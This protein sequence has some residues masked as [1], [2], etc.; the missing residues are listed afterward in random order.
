MSVRNLDSLFNPSS[1]ALVGSSATPQTVGAVATRN[2]FAAGFHG[3]VYLVNPAGIVFGENASIDVN[4]S[5]H[6]S[7]ADYLKLGINGRFDASNPGNTVLSANS[8]TGTSPQPR[9][10]TTSATRPASSQS[11][12]RAK[13]ATASAT[14]ARSAAVGCR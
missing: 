14:P 6:A 5:F 10:G 4:G 12:S 2:I 3:D 11:R 7:T 1:V 9:R 8:S 13:L